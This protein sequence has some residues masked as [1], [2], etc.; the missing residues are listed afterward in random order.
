MQ[1][2]SVESNMQEYSS[3]TV[4]NAIENNP[5]FKVN[6][7]AKM[8]ISIMASIISIVLST[9]EGLLCL[10]GVS[11]CYVICMENKKILLIAYLLASAMFVIA[12]SFAYLLS[13]VSPIPF[14]VGGIFVPFLRLAIMLHVILPLAFGSRIQNILVSLKALHL[15]FFIYLPVVVMIRF[16]PTFINDVKQISE[17]LKI[18]GYKLGFVNT[19]LHPFMMIR[20]LFT[21]LIFRSLKTSEELGIAGEL[22]GLSPSI[23]MTSYK[24]EKWHNKDTILILV[25]IL[26]VCAALYIEFN[27]GT[28]GMGGHR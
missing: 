4:E 24:F 6:T 28:T 11:F 5:K 2:L 12:N 27:Y 18:R 23:K 20:L 14:N 8:M 3:K 16:I 17:T 26:T 10:F 25:A 9:P 19:M 13:L 7:I 22:K 15:P 21:P 1:E